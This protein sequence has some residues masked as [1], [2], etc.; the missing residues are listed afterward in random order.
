MGYGV[1]KDDAK[2]KEN[3]VNGVK[4]STDYF[5]NVKTTSSFYDAKNPNDSY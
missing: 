4:Q 3:F 2:A 5:W 1:S